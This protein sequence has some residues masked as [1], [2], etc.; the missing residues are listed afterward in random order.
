MANVQV[1]GTPSEIEADLATVM[2][3]GALMSSPAGRQTDGSWTDAGLMACQQIGNIHSEMMTATGSTPADAAA[4]LSYI[5]HFLWAALRRGDPADNLLD[6]ARLC[7]ALDFTL[8][9]SG[10][11]PK[12]RID[13]DAAPWRDN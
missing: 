7:A 9:Q 8:Q 11:L 4:L 13:P 2:K 3:L 10:V 1:P 6:A 5:R 12:A